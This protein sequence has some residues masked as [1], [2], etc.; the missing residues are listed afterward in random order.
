MS[1]WKRKTRVKFC[2]YRLE[3]QLLNTTWNKRMCIDKNGNDNSDGVCRKKCQVKVKNADLIDGFQVH[4]MYL[5][6]DDKIKAVLLTL[7]R[8]VLLFW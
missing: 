5:A 1:L 4:V 8:E 7:F 6:D 2:K 3:K